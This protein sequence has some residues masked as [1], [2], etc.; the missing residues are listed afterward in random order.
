MEQ[1]PLNEPAILAV[2]AE[3]RAVCAAISPELSM[4]GERLLTRLQPPYSALEWGLPGWLGDTFGLTPSAIHRLTLSNMLGL[5]YVWLLDDLADGEVREAERLA[6]CA[7]TTTL[8]EHALLNYQALFP[9]D[10]PFWIYLRRWLDDWLRALL[11]SHSP[12]AVAPAASPHE[13]LHRLAAKGAPRKI[14]CAA[15]CLLAGSE[16]ALEPL[17]RSLDHLMAATVLLDDAHDCA[18]DLAAGSW[19]EFVAYVSALPQAPEQREANRRLVLREL[20]EGQQGRPYFAALREHVWAAQAAAHEAGVAG[21]SQYLAW[22]ERAVDAYATAFAGRAAEA[23]SQL[24][25][26]VLGLFVERQKE[27]V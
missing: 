18:A 23:I 3:L 11:A 21:L 17:N 20:I 16:A 2:S 13:H 19:N 5:G 24:T 15:A 9:A 26:R 22:F 14:C 10:S 6:T 1:L 27:V 7:L 12:P 4:A 25:E 8:Y